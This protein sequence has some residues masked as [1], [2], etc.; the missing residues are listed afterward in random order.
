MTNIEPM[1]IW[2]K[3][4]W[5]FSVYIQSLI[6]CLQRFKKEIESENLNEAGIELETAAELMIASAAAMK[7]A[8]SFTRQIYEDKIRPMMTPPNV[9]SENFSGLMH[10]DHAHLTTILRKIQPLYK[11]LPDS[12]QIQHDKFISAY[13][14]LSDSHKNVCQKFGGDEMGSLR[15]L[16][17]TAIDMLNKFERNRLR[18]INPTN[19]SLAKCPFHENDSSD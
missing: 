19:R 4:H 13:A 1:E 16:N 18:L 5:I 15:E 2:Q 14:I 11:T 8:G 6:I 10:W 3:Y 9:K 7:E 17:H 12:L